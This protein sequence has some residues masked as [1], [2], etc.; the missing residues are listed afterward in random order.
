M[1]KAVLVGVA[2]FVVCGLH[3]SKSKQRTQIRHKAPLDGHSLEAKNH[4]GSY[5]L[6]SNP[7]LTLQANQ[8]LEQALQNV[9]GVRVF[10]ATGVGAM[11]SF[12]MRG[13]GGGYGRGGL[14][15]LNNIPLDAAPYGL[16]GLFIFIATLQMSDQISVIKGGQGVQYGPNAFGGVINIST[17]PIAKEWTNQITQ[18]VTFW[19]RSLKNFISPFSFSKNV[20]NSFLYNTYL[21]SGGMFN[22]FVGVQAQ[23]NF[24][25]G[26]GFRYHSPATIQNYLFD[27]IYQINPHNKL[28]ASFQYY[29]FSLHD[30]GSLSPQAYA[31]NYFQN[32][33]PYNT[34]GA[35]AMRWSAIYQ[36]SFKGKMDGDFSLTYFG[37]KM[38]SA[39]QWDSNYLNANSNPARG[40]VYTNDNYAGFFTT[41][42]KG[43][44]TLNALEPN[45]HL[46]IS[47]KKLQQTLQV[48]MRL[49]MNDIKLTKS[50]CHTFKNNQCAQDPTPSNSP[51]LLDRYLGA[52]VS[53]KM[54]FLQGK[55][56]LTPGL[57][58][59]FLNEQLAP[60]DTIYKI[61]QSI[62]SPAFNIGYKP[63]TDW[64]LYAN[65]RRSFIPPQERMVGPISPS[66]QI[67]NQIEIGSR[68]AYQNQLSLNATY[69]LI[70]AHNYYAWGGNQPI[71]ARSQGLELELDYTPI[72]GLQL[73]VAYT[74]INALVSSDMRGS[75]EGFSPSFDL[76]GKQLPYVSPHQLILDMRYTYKKTTLGL[77]SY[78]Y[79]SAYSSMLNQSQSKTTCFPTHP[80]QANGVSYAC[81]SVGLL[82]WYWIWNIQLSQIF[83][84]SG[85]HK[86]VGSLQV[87]N[88]LGMPY[89][90]RG[91][92]T[93]PTGR[94]PG[95]GRSVTAYLSYRF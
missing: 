33:R 14:V 2:C 74:Y 41:Q 46:N 88:I 60:K 83:W 73:H 62:W 71:N 77:S 89:Y 15:L 35:E 90:F 67:F 49:M 48:G 31:Q 79:S 42:Y 64:L 59:T 29:K 21:R 70:F 94:E 39:F 24:I 68:Y 65:Y 81:H 37:H 91:L 54:E 78:F 23:A 76:K 80:H 3:A 72:R 56:T 93:S 84:E 43:S 52:Y 47:S 5:T 1:K 12:S 82:P 86:I 26:Q 58:Y 40:L 44:F 92:E 19:E 32:D 61:H 34:K 95:P 13:L 20:G 7:Q 85:R 4:F 36:S 10:N 53:D 9:P 17:K 66:T 55:L 87:N 57:R 11:P 38:Q 30:P 22:R 51:E 16:I 45:L 27:G 8:T 69:F 25:T 6:I 75:L 28:T 18:R 63:L 50:I